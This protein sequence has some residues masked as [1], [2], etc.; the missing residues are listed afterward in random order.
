MK[1]AKVKEQ[2]ADDG[3]QPA[4][5]SKFFPEDDKKAAPVAK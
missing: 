2:P 3:A 5:K 1:A 4:K